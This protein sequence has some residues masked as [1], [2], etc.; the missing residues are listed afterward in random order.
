M[1]L[2]ARGT[3]IAYP[4]PAGK[5]RGSDRR[6]AGPCALPWKRGSPIL[7]PEPETGEAHPGAAP[8]SAANHA[9]TPALAVAPERDSDFD[10]LLLRPGLRLHVRPSRRFKSVW[11]D[12]F[13]PRL[14]RPVAATRMALVGRL[15]ERGTAR[16]PG[17]R[18]LNRHTDDLYG[19]F[20][21]SQT[22]GMGPF[23]VLH[24]HYEAVEGAY[25]PGRPDLL[26]PGLELLGQALREPYLEGGVFPEAR[27]EQEKESLRR[28]VEAMYS[29]RTAL[30]QRRCLEI[31]CAGEAYGL[32]AHG[33]PSELCGVTGSDLLAELA[34][35]RASAALD[36]YICGDVDVD[37]A[38]ALAEA[39]LGWPR[40]SLK[41]TPPPPVHLA[42][43]GVRRVTERD[44][45]AQGR[46]MLGYRTDA[47][48]GGGERCRYPALALLDLIFGADQ[49]SRLWRVVREES[50]MC[51]YITSYGEAMGGML[52]VEAGVEAGDRE[53]VG[54]LVRQQL[55]ELADAGPGGGELERSRTLALN[56]LDSFD[57]ARDRLV[58]FDYYRRLAGAD[59]SRTRLRQALA[60][61]DAAE[62]RAAAARLV[63][64]TDYFL[65][66][67]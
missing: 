2:E 34:G 12:L 18:Q 50:G 23:Q 15:L 43:E 61:V 20:F 26:A 60:G 57:D 5:P 49:H 19:A 36:L 7:D 52:F 32:A 47:T 28:S 63:L 40:P 30:A 53:A 25:L 39:A 65:A 54:R 33:D 4:Q 62:I 17:L 27:V 21:S 35:L 55:R 41:A 45:L 8:D 24:L 13:L 38:A 42:G 31:M 56:R 46:M 48:V 37:R 66:P 3:I 1:V 59:T 16:L 11:I 64:E 9:P 29:D 67:W 58:R 44:R 22:E 10:S 6:T 51:Y 14:L